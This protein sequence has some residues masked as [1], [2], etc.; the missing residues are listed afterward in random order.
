M[1]RQI[2]NIGTADKGN[3]DPIRVAFEKANSNFAEL[4]AILAGGGGAQIIETDIKGSVFADD[5]TVMVDS[6]GNKIFANTAELGNIEITGSTISTSDSSG[7]NINQ[8]VNLNS[9]VNVGGNLIPNISNGGDLGSLAKPWKSLYVSNSTVFL[10]GVPLSLEPGTNELRVNNIPVSQSI[11]YTD[12]PNAPVDVSD[13]TD[14][15]NLLGGGGGDN[16][17]T[18]EEPDYWDSPT[19]NTVQA[20]LDELAAKVAALENFE[21]DGGNAYTP[22]AGELLIDG[23]GA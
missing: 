3:G 12:I 15:R 23:N 17:Y 6:V 9:D 4:Y 21:I 14:T 5:S 19:V 20:A 10:G 22:A 8:V 1:T 7:I 16:S 13:L 11:T 18:P 2:I